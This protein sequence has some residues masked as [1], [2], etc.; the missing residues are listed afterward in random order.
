MAIMTHGLSANGDSA[1]LT[2]VL[3]TASAGLMTGC[4]LPDRFAVPDCT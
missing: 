4:L 1:K 2:H 3:K